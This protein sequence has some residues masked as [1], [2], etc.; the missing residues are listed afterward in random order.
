[1]SVLTDFYNLR[2]TKNG[3]ADKDIIIEFFKKHAPKVLTYMTAE[4]TEQ[5]RN[6]LDLTG[7]LGF[8]ESRLG[9][10]WFDSINVN[11]FY[12]WYDSLHEVVSSVLN[13]GTIQKKT[14]AWIASLP[15]DVRTE[16]RFKDDKGN[17]YSFVDSPDV[18][19][20]RAYSFGEAL[21]SIDTTSSDIKRTE[22]GLGSFKYKLFRETEALLNDEIEV[23]PCAA[24][25]C[26][27]IFIP[28]PKNVSKQLYC[29]S[30][31]RTRIWRRQD[32]AARQMETA[33]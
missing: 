25:D 23:R 19:D 29:S 20:P 3:K 30:T 21:V 33:K 9:K 12:F 22:L 14:L 5:S 31:C 17:V 13:G 11:N 28:D 6:L 7:T 4:D 2:L 1:M 32:R 16:F 8:F 24:E 10:S 26:S 18:I 15:K 27:N